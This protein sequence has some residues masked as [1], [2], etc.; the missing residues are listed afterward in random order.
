MPV[1]P[2]LVVF[3]CDGV[4]VDTEGPQA[5]VMAEVLAGHGASVTPQEILA[6]YKGSAL[7]AIARD[8]RERT[9][10]VL[11][12]GWAQEFRDRRGPAFER[13]GITAVHGVRVVVEALVAAGIPYGVA[14]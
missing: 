1:R 8:L 2:V 5:A 12:A 9:G 14:S 3:D 4:L 13:D 6:R 10:V 11:P 7:E